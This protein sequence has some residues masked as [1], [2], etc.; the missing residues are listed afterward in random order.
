MS[1]FDWQSVRWNTRARV[2]SVVAFIFDDAARGV[3]AGQ[4]GLVVWDAGKDEHGR[5][6]AGR[7]V[8]TSDGRTV[9]VPNY[10]LRSAGQQAHRFTMPS[11]PVTAYRVTYWTSTTETVTAGTLADAYAAAGY[12]SARDGSHM[13]DNE[14]GTA[15]VTNEHG[16]H[17]ATIAPVVCQNTIAGLALVSLVKSATDTPVTWARCVESAELF[18]QARGEHVELLGN[19]SFGKIVRPEF[20]GQSIARGE[21]RPLTRF[22]S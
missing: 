17:C 13:W 11:A 7:D 10:E 16:D 12:Y 3:T 8:L 21:L 22:T 5:S 6:Q 4:L 18:E 14:D 15:S 9:N 19:A 1:T 20:G 2:G